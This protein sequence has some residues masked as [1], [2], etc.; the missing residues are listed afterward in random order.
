MSY[1]GGKG[2]S[3]QQHPVFGQL[4]SSPWAEKAPMEMDI[5]PQEGQIEVTQTD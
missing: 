1:K 5:V 3:R 2:S 4:H